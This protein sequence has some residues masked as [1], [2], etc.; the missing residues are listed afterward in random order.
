MGWFS[1]PKTNAGSL[2]WEQLTDSA[3]LDSLLNDQDTPIILFKH[4]TRCSISSMAL[5]RFE[6]EWK[7]ELNCRLV[8]L[9][10]L[11]HRNIS[12]D[13]ATKTGV[14]HQ[15]PQAILVFKGKVIGHASHNGISANKFEQLILNL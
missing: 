14:E 9:D 8:F 3:K 6:S 10:L 7:N 2:N 4:S 11:S 15:S 5:S 1:S 12:N 13:I